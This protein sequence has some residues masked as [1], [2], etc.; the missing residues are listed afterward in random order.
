MGP[1][2]VSGLDW[3]HK[4]IKLGAHASGPWDLLSKLAYNNPPVDARRLEDSAKEAPA[5]IQG[6]L[7][8]VG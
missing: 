8:F 5:A 2:Y 1:C 7:Q 4:I 6:I 3:V